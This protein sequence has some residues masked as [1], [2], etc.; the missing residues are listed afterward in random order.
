MRDSYALWVGF[1][2]IFHLPFDTF[3][4]V[5]EAKNKRNFRVNSFYQ[6]ATKSTASANDK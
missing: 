6:E 1:P 3:H 5:I 4:F 2:F